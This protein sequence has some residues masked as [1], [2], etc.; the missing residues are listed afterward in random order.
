MAD[1][2]ILRPGR[3]IR[4]QSMRALSHSFSD[5]TAATADIYVYK[6][7][8]WAGGTGGACDI[9]VI[10]RPRAAHLHNVILGHLHNASIRGAA[11]LNLSGCLSCPGDQSNRQILSHPLRSQPPDDRPASPPEAKSPRAS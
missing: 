9:N 2:R 11:A 6:S 4:R 1:G 7:D 5:L 3:F 10:Q 8:L